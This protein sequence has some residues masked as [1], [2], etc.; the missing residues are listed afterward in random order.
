ML[1]KSGMD[2]KFPG[3]PNSSGLGSIPGWGTEIPQATWC[4]Q[5]KRMDNKMQYN[6]SKEYCAVMRR[7]EVQVHTAF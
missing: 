6:Y 7:G 5:K 2:G 1:I 4:G 3:G